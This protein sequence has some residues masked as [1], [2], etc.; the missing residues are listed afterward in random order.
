MADDKKPA[1]EL[2]QELMEKNNLIVSSVIGNA[3]STETGKV[4]LTPAIRVSYKK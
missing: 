2:F 4:I 1:Q 3:E